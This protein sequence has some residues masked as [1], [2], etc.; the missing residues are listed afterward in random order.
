M[1]RRLRRRKYI[2]FSNCWAL[3]CSFSQLRCDVCLYFLISPE[4]APRAVVHIKMSF[5][6]K[7][8]LD[9]ITLGRDIGTFTWI[10]VWMVAHQQ[11]SPSTYLLLLTTTEHVNVSSRRET[12]GDQYLCPKLFAFLPVVVSVVSVSCYLKTLWH[13]DFIHQMCFAINAKIKN[14]KILRKNNNVMKKVLCCVPSC[15]RWLKVC[16]W[17]VVKHFA[18]LSGP[19]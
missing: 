1:P 15:S 11:L 8:P 16:V 12:W 5:I 4:K 6:S 10:H 17:E 9:A 14:N 2:A 3:F 13:N 18:T 7:L 19:T